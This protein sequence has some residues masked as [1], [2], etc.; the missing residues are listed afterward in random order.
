MVRA[1]RYL[2][3][4]DTTTYSPWS[5]TVKIMP[6]ASPSSVTLHAPEFVRRG[7]PIELSWEYEGDQ[8]QTGYAVRPASAPKTSWASGKGTSSFASVSAKRYGRADSVELYVDVATGGDATSSNHVT[9][10]I[11]DTPTCR[12][13]S[14]SACTANPYQLTVYSS[15]PDTDLLV[16]VYSLG[17]ARSAPDGDRDQLYSDVVWTASL[18]P[19]W[20]ASGGSYSA[21]V[22]IPPDA[23]LVDGC[24]YAV[25]ARVRDRATGLTSSAVDVG[26]M[27]TFAV[28]WAHKAPKPSD[29]IAVTADA[30]SRLVEIALATPDGAAE[31]DVYDVWRKTGTG[32]DAVAIDVPLDATVTD[33]LAPFGTEPDLEYR[34]CLRTSDGDESFDDYPYSM[35]VDVL[36]IDF[37]G[38]FVELPYNVSMAGSWTKSF[39]SR[40]HMDGSVGGYWDQGVARSGSFSSAIA[41]P[42]AAQ[43]EGLRALAM[44]H[45]AVFVRTPDG[46]AFQANVD[47]ALDT[48][49]ESQIVGASLSVT[50]VDLT[51]EYRVK[52]DD[53]V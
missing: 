14:L 32:Y 53:I 28:A 19:S 2:E 33:R 8:A 37:G 42:D 25:G 50:E 24:T 5:A 27:P 23:D 3:T 20:V 22:E 7:Q 38:S 36:R 4:D 31:S 40:V 39:E 34:I 30:E 48:T 44:W 9:V 21:T 15:D 17:V 10:G 16:S 11:A 12:L 49:Y 47:V 41:R 35:G 13:A 46:R 29:D 6:T 43:I 51:D 45:G 52:S 26:L 1:R 18:S